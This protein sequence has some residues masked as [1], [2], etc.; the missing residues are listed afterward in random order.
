MFR[1]MMNGKI[2]RATVTEANLNYVGSITIDED[3]LDA[4]GMIANEK[5]Q[6]VNNNN[7]ARLETYIIPGERGSGVICLNGAA[8]RLVQKG[9]I[10]II[11]S[12]ALIAEEKVA[13][14]KPKVAIMDEDNR[15]KELINAEP[16]LTIM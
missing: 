1:N 6:I 5:V 11:I 16:A 13:A 7:G 15:I 9:D 12:Y 3:L 14:H 2:H 8:A 10:V 4:V